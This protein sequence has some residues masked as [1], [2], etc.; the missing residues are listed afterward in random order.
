[1]QSSIINGNLGIIRNKD[2]PKAKMHLNHFAEKVDFRQS[3][4]GL[5]ESEDYQQLISF[6]M[7]KVNSI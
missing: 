6:C 7:R 3:D 5:V 1:M 2:L 4:K